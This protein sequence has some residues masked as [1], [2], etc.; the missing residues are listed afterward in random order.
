VA[1]LER[2]A[3]ARKSIHTRG[4]KLAMKRSYL[5]V[6]VALILWP[7]SL[8]AEHAKI[9]LKLIHLDPAS[10]AEGEEVVA[11]ADQEPPLGGSNKRPLAKVKAGE[12]LML[13]FFLTNTYPHGVKKDVTVRYYVVREEKQGQKNVPDLKT[14]TVTEGRF[15]MNFKPNCRV[16]AQVHFKIN[17]PGIYLLR[18][19]TL[20]TDSDHEHFAAI[21]VRVDKAP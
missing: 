4:G 6:G 14:G 3:V 18:I 9:D 15:K 11:N 17:E 21:D 16:G 2:P 5:L 12:P 8:R 13:R 7:L 10:G 1:R 19:E 20:N